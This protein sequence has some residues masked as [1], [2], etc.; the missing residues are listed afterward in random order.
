M[1]GLG[2]FTAKTWLACLAAMF[3]VTTAAQAATMLQIQ[4]NGVDLQF[5][6]NNLVDGAAGSAADVLTGVEFLGDND[7]VIGT[8]STDTTLGLFIPNVPNIPITGGQVSS[9][10]N[11]SLDLNLGDGEFLSLTL[12]S[13]VITYVTYLANPFDPTSRVDFVFTGSAGTIDGQNLPFGLVLGEPVTI[14]FSTQIAANS[15]TSNGTSL[16]GFRSVG[17]G[18]IQ[19]ASVA[20]PVPE[21]VAMGMAGVALIAIRRLSKSRKGKRVF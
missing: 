10:I 9:A 15:K 11:G 8:D 21:P 1:K 19:G 4:M 14:T 7:V 13:A 12:G 2:M 6:G 20:V 17:T 16:T 3:A 5:V 18:E